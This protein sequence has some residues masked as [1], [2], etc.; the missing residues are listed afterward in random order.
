MSYKKSK[1]H[2]I[3]NLKTVIDNHVPIKK[4]AEI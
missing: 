1:V 2:P 4:T 3:S